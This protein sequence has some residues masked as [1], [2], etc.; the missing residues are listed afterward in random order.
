MGF[1]NL[2]KFLP[3]LLIPLWGCSHDFGLMRFEESINGYRSA[4]RW[5]MFEKALMFHANADS[6]NIDFSKL[7]NLKVT[8]YQPLARRE[9]EGGKTATQT[10]EIRYVDMERLAEKTITDKQVWHYDEARGTWVI[11]SG[12]PKFR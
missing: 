5:G 1:H 3:L 7:K 8:S 11:D 12:F 9:F 10:V 6:M 2:K 4:I